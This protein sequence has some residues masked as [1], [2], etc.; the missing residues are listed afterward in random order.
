MP[1]PS[2]KMDE[3]EKRICARFKEARERSGISQK[4]FAHMLKVSLDR[5]K[6]LEYAR[7]P[8]KSDIAIRMAQWTGCNLYW[9]AE[10]AGPQDGPLPDPDLIGQFPARG[11]FSQ[12]WDTQLKKT[13]IEGEKNFGQSRK[14]VRE[15]L[16][17]G[18][19]SA[20]DYSIEEVERC[21][22][23]LF[24]GSHWSLYS[25]ICKA[26]RNFEK[27]NREK[28]IELNAD[29]IKRQKIADNKIVLKDNIKNAKDALPKLL[30]RLKKITDERGKKTALAKFL[31]VPL[32]SVSHW[33]SGIK[34][35]GGEA[36]LQ[37]LRWI[38]QQKRQKHDNQTE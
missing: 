36:T 9:L 25:C 19:F 10:G 16:G 26:C 34:K 22:E 15:T 1:K 4:T 2:G 21:F 6:S 23:N 28:I 18:G 35:P 29:H 13:F 17:A 38:A 27:M 12:F 7:T 31:N 30:E 3:R 8:L 37:M 5:L 24:P 33:L 11:L 32:T 20:L 14:S